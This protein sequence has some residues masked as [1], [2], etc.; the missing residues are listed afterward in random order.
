MKVSAVA[1]ALTA[2]L[3]V[4]VAQSLSGLPTCAQSCVQLPSSCNPLDVKC[5]CSAQSFLSSI[6]CCVAHA[7][8][9]ADQETTVKFAQQLCGS[10]GVTSIPS[11]AVCP[12]STS[13][14]SGTSATSV[15]SAASA[16]SHTLSA[17]G[18]SQTTPGTTSPSSNGTATNSGTGTATAATSAS[19]TSG[20]SAAAPIAHGQNGGAFAAMAA[21]AAF[22]AILLM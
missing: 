8:S 9:Q 15:A 4:A 2:L 11:A 3:T 13:G 12:T 21:A 1:I 14:A 6:T 10:A 7:C 22:V 20:T 16:A 17:S 18:L 5:I 19:K